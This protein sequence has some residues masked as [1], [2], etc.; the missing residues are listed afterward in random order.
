VLHTRR[1]VSLNPALQPRYSP[2]SPSRARLESGMTTRANGAQRPS[3]WALTKEK[4]VCTR[5][6]ELSLKFPQRRCHLVMSATLKASLIR[7][8]VLRLHRRLRLAPERR[9]KMMFHLGRCRNGGPCTIPAQRD[10]HHRQRKDPQSTGLTS[11]SKPD[12]KWMTAHDMHLHLNGTR[13]TRTSCPISRS[14]PCG[15]LVYGKA[16]SSGS[17]KP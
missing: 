12:V 16:I 4:F 8:S 1:I 6:T 11:S 2:S 14:P 9:M 13:S 3:S 5:S 10:L 15:R 17:A 7:N